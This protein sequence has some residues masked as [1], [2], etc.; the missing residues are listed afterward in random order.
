MEPDPRFLR[1]LLFKKRLFAS[2]I[3][4]WA[5]NL[6]PAV[7]GDEELGW[8]H[9][10]APD[11]CAHSRPT[12]CPWQINARSIE[13]RPSQRSLSTNTAYLKCH[14]FVA[15]SFV[16]LLRRYFAQWAACALFLTATMGCESM[17]RLNRWEGPTDHGQFSVQ[18]EIPSE[19]NAD[20]ITREKCVCGR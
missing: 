17:Q 15:G 8:S 18:D 6:T 19:V 10:R 16:M 20:D 3:F 5:M 7:S 9:S 11:A 4:H 13:S 14:L 1:S 2:E 12:N